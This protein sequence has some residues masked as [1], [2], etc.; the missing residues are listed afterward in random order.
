[1][2]PG[3]GAALL[4]MVQALAQSHN[5]MHTVLATPEMYEAAM[6]SDRPI[7][8]TLMAEYD[9]VLAG[10]A[11]WHRSFSTNRGAEVMYLED[12]SVLPEFRRRGIARAL[13]KAVAQLALE[14][15]YPGIYWLMM[16]WNTEAKNLY[17]SVGA[18]IEPGTTFCRIRD[19][20]LRALAS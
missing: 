5:L 19:D 8:G 9:G 2:K 20:A 6:F 11:V 16:D 17:A 18:E 12:L 3:E 7:V 15:N 13:L 10:C 1:M 14:K 4:S